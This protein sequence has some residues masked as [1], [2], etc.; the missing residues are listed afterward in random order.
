M[1]LLS[2]SLHILLRSKFR[3]PSFFLQSLKSWHPRNRSQYPCVFSFF[4]YST[5]V[6]LWLMCSYV[7]H[8][9]AAERDTMRCCRVEYTRPVQSTQTLLYG[10]ILVAGFLVYF[11]VI[12]FSS[13]ER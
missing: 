12:Y 11:L 7:E 1:L 5:D 13:S 3:L 8:L 9:I 10:G 6:V 2:C 4:K